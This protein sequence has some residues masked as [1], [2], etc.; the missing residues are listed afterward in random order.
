MLIKHN[1][2]SKQ[3]G[4]L[5]RRT[6]SSLEEILKLWRLREDYLGDVYICDECRKI[7]GS[8]KLPEGWEQRIM[9]GNMLYGEHHFCTKCKD[10]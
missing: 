10:K 7:V 2:T 8:Q 4:E 6:N 9:Y 1:M 5:L 3:C